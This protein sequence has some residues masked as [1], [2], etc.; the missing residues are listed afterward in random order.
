MEVKAVVA[1]LTGTLDDIC[2]RA[3]S[4]QAGKAVLDSELQG[5]REG[6]RTA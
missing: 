1:H 3:W 6:K 5:L 4:F 2:L